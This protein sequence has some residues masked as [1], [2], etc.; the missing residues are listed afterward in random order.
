MVEAVAAGFSSQLNTVAPDLEIEWRKELADTDEAD[1]TFK[2]CE[3]QTDAIVFLGSPGAQYLASNPPKI[4]CFVGACNDPEAL[5]VVTNSHAPDKNI[6]G[7]TYAIPI[8]KRFDVLKDLFPNVRSVALLLTK[9]HPSSS[10]D[11][12]RTKAECERRTI[13]Y[14]EVWVESAADMTPKLKEMVGKADLFIIGTSRVPMDNVATILAVANPAR[15]PVFSYAKK[16]V[17]S[18]AT[19]GMAA[20]DGKLGQML[21]DSVADVVI[22]N[23]PVS[24]VPIKTDPHPQIL[25]NQ[26]MMRAFKV[27][28]PE[29]LL[30]WATIV[31]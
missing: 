18:G 17:A 29:R 21:A 7:V 16:P 5:G 28:I 22:G 15:I 27:G 13:A 9:D 11:Q 14:H 19:A 3:T 4:P 31:K 30:D 6:T 25:L 10:I 2:E 8:A 12:M 26:V 1:R 20:D 23:R 24:Q